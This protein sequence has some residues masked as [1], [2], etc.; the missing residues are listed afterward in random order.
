[1]KEITIH[2]EG[3]SPL[4][5]CNPGLSMQKDDTVKIETK[6][7]YDPAVEAE[8]RTYRLGSKQ[9]AMRAAAFRS[10]MV[11]AATGRKLG[12]RAATSVVSGSVF[13]TDDLIGL[14]EPGTATPIFDY[15][16]DSRRVVVQKQGVLRQRP[17]F[18]K[19]ATTVHFEI[20]DDFITEAHCVEF[21]NLAGRTVGVG[22]FRPEKKGPFGRF[23]VVEVDAE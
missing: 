20:D 6:K 4:L 5:L 21:L 12:K 16:I 8:M 3:T 23:R 10:A 2:I 19:W 18:E 22:D 14:Y 7:V 17:K 13:E 9:H 11:K 1:M 15:V